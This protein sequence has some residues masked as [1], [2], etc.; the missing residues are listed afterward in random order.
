M[1]AV[2]SGV[3]LFVAVVVMVGAL[4]IGSGTAAICSLLLVIISQLTLVVG[5]GRA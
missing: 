2:A 4:L 1:P 3:L 5:V